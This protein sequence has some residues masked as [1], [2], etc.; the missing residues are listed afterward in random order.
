[1]LQIRGASGSAGEDQDRLAAT[2][3]FDHQR[4]D[5]GLMVGTYATTVDDLDYLLSLGLPVEQVAQRMGRTVT[6][7]ERMI[8]TRTMGNTG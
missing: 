3:P 2:N 4:E 1:M 7:V 6:A 5:A 8:D